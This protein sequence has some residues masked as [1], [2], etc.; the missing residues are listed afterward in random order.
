MHHPAGETVAFAVNDEQGGSGDGRA[1]LRRAALGSVHH[2]RPAALKTIAT[3]ELAFTDPGAIFLDGKNVLS[4][5]VEVDCALA[6]SATSSWS[7]SSP[8]RS[9]AASSTCGSSAS[10]GPR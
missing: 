1:R 4:L 2:G 6:G 10:G 5:V 7:A 8:R 9:P 3:G